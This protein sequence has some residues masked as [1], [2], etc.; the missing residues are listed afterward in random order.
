[1]L[2]LDSCFAQALPDEITGIYPSDSDIAQD[3]GQRSQ[4]SA[5]KLWRLFRCVCFGRL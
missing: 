1:M 2:L 4:G 3:L 5:E